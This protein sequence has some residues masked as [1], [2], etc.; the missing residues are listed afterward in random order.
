MKSELESVFLKICNQPITSHSFYLISI[1]FILISLFN[2]FYFLFYFSFLQLIFFN[3]IIYYFIKFKLIF[4]KVRLYRATRPSDNSC[5]S[6]NTQSFTGI[7]S[8]LLSSERQLWRNTTYGHAVRHL[9]PSS[10]LQ[11]IWQQSQLRENWRKYKCWSNRQRDSQN[12]N[13][14]R[15]Q[16]TVNYL[17]MKL[18]WRLNFWIAIINAARVTGVLRKLMANTDGAGAWPKD[19][20]SGYKVSIIYVHKYDL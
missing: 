3:L 16:N 11:M 5:V 19:R 9:P 20:Y 12:S 13:T 18:D 6:K 2:L 14:E 4:A 17:G 1:Y 8:F 10:T 7:Y 15:P